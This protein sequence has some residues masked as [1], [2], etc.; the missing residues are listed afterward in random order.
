MELALQ[1]ARSLPA[2][3]DSA[4]DAEAVKSLY[5]ETFGRVNV[6]IVLD[7]EG[8]YTKESAFARAFTVAQTVVV[9]QGLDRGRQQLACIP[10]T[11]LNLEAANVFASQPEMD[12]IVSAIQRGSH[13][14]PCQKA[15]VECLP[16]PVPRIVY[17]LCEVV[18][19][20]KASIGSRNTVATLLFLNEI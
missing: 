4:L 20:C 14:S 5:F 19:R 16:D 1:L 18:N 15:I 6:G 2:G 17:A 10:H 11:I 3:E 8:C 13:P 7:G 9:D 12:E